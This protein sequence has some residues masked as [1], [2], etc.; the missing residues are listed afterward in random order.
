MGVT[1]SPLGI[2]LPA[3]HPLKP[4][5]LP[6]QAARMTARN[7]LDEVFLQDP[8][9]QHWVVVGRG[10]PMD[11]LRIGFSARM[12]D[13]P[14]MVTALDNEVNSAREGVE[15]LFGFYGRKG[16]AAMDPAVS[17]VGQTMV[18]GAT[19]GGVGT[20]GWLLRRPV[21]ALAPAVGT[22]TGAVTAGVMPTVA[23][24]LLGV[25]VLVGVSAVGA[26]LWGHFRKARPETISMVLH[27]ESSLPAYPDRWRGR[28]RHHAP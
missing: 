6:E 25:G 18:A 23:G 26:A 8:Q 19:M 24:F 12:G 11:R 15:R 5:L 10:L 14:V 2:T 20:V 3:A 7:G 1:F 28:E 21:P 16:Q 13:V 9:G 4:N 27:G 22:F 17:A